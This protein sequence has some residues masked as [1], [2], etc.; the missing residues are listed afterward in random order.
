MNTAILVTTGLLC[1]VVLVLITLFFKQLKGLL[2]LILNTAL[3]WA[4]LYIF[5]LIFASSGFL[6]GVNIASATV[7]G[8]LGIPGLL[9]MIILKFIYKGL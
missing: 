9:L 5:N 7:V 3:G 6:I 8:V 2:L 4:G 1:A